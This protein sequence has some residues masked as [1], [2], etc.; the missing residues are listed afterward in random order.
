MF[1]VFYYLPHNI[2]WGETDFLGWKICYNIEKKVL[3]ENGL[4][5]ISR[6]FEEL[7]RSNVIQ[8]LFI[9]ECI[10][11]DYKE[12]DKMTDFLRGFKISEKFQ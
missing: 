10:S 8:Y 12:F 11:K 5:G 1:T 6:D 3:K 2:N 9:Y 4:Q 7:K